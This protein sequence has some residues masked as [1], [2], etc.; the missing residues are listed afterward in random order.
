VILA[1]VAALA[2]AQDTA[3]AR[4][5]TPAGDSVA[6]LDF[7]TFH[8]Q[9]RR[10]HPVARQAELLEA[11]ASA[12]L[13]AARAPLWDPVLGA[14]WSRKEF[15]ASEYYNYLE[16]G[17]KV[18]T[19]VGVEFK[20]GYERTQGEFINPDRTTPGD[21]LW[22]AGVSIPVGQGL[23]SDARRNALAEARGLRDIAVAERQ[24]QVNKL[25]FA[26]A[27]DYAAWY[28]AWRRRSVAREGFEL[29][30]TRYRFVQRRF[31]DGDAAAIDTVE[32]GLEL[33]RRIVAQLEAD[34]AW[35]VTSQVIST[36]LWDDRA[37]PY[38]LGPG[39]VP[40]LAGLAPSATDTTALDG[41]LARALAQHPDLQKALAK[42]RVAETNRR[43]YGQEL[44]PDITFDVAALKDGATGP[45]QDWPG[46]D[47]NYKFGLAGKTSLLLMKER[48]AFNAAG[49]K[50]ESAAL[51]IAMVRR[52]LRATVLASANEAV[53]FQR[54]AEV[55]R[56]AVAQARVLRDG[57]ARRFQEGESTLFV[58]NQRDRLLLDEA[59][60]LAGYEAK[61][62]GA[63]AALAVA[64]GGSLAGDGTV[65]PIAEPPR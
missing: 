30:D 9:V 1:L 56:S 43:Y 21:G 13:L 46:S 38:D 32:A 3:T 59:V 49:A 47:A 60:K 57:E 23:I 25:L 58:L 8:E 33:Q 40:T 55:Q 29:A 28:E 4:L 24:A 61:Y 15:K 65:T 31:E 5:A 34:N 7:A 26:A 51:E 27:K 17:L 37:V 39:V 16:A 14:E 53:A 12:E 45:F 63:R 62:L 11:R 54:I 35:F 18:P 52:D 42:Q 64:L 41:W 50:L 10:R 22:V 20:L 36:Y 44:L 2:F 6:V 19:P 48:G